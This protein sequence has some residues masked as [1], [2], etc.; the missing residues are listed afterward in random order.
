M[1]DDPHG[2][3]KHATLHPSLDFV[4]NSDLLCVPLQL[5]H[6]NLK[7]QLGITVGICALNEHVPEKNGD[8]YTTSTSVTTGTSQC[9]APTSPTRT[10]YLAVTGGFGI[11]ADAHGQAKLQQLVFPFQIFYG[12]S[13]KIVEFENFLRRIAE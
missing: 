6:E 4:F 7:K 3:E 12:V 5:F 8:D 2:S 9:M 10:F 11:F 13:L 1:K